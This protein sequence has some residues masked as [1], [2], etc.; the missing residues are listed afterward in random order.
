VLDEHPERSMVKSV[1]VKD[2]IIKESGNG[3]GFFNII[4]KLKL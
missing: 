3:M 1:Q 2:K 4:D